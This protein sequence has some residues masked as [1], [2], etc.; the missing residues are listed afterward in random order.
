MAVD[1]TNVGLQRV[2]DA[3]TADETVAPAASPEPQAQAGLALW[4]QPKIDIKQ[5]CLAGAE[6]FVRLDGAPPPADLDEDDLAGLTEQALRTALGDWSVF[7]AAGLNL[8]LSIDVPVNLLDRLPIAAIVGESRPAAEHWPGLIV[9][10]AEDQI[11]R[12]IRRSQE[13]AAKLRVSGITVAIDDFGAGYSS[14]ASLRDIAFAE[15]KL[16]ASFVKGC[17]GDP[18]NAA[19][20]QTAIDLAHR[21]G[22]TAVAEGIETVADLQAMQIMGC[23]FA[24]GTLIAPPMAKDDFL[25]LLR[26]RMN[27]PRAP[28]A[29]TPDEQGPPAAASA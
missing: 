19:I 10:V 18:T 7:D 24:Q 29:A 23:D 26:A 8:R 17:A 28:K 15:L 4:Y 9:E 2:L 20:C 6:A 22:S 16:N 14:F 5:R 21:F 25:A 27:K 12:D 13:I 1:E 11:A 3:L